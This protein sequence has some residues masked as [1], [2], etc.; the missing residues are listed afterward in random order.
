MSH[1]GLV[2]DAAADGAE[3]GGFAGGA[4][5]LEDPEVD[6]QR[7]PLEVEI[8]DE[9]ERDVV[10]VPEGEH[11]GE[12][13]LEPVGFLLL[14]VGALGAGPDRDLELGG[15]R[16]AVDVGDDPARTGEL[17]LRRRLDERPRR[18]A[19]PDLEH[20]AAVVAPQLVELVV[21]EQVVQRHPQVGPVG[22][23]LAEIIE[24][25]LLAHRQ[26]VGLVDVGAPSVAEQ[27]EIALEPA[28]A[29]VGQH[30]VGAHRQVVVEPA[31]VAGI[32][33]EVERA[34]RHRGAPEQGVVGGPVELPEHLLGGRRRGVA[35]GEQFERVVEIFLVPTGPQAGLLA[36]VAHPVCERPARAPGG[37][38]QADSRRAD[39]PQ[40][41]PALRTEGP[42]AEQ[43][44]EVP[45]VAGAG[46]IERGGLAGA[47]GVVRRRRDD[48][49]P[50][51]VPAVGREVGD[52]IV[53][54]VLAGDVA[55]VAG[56]RIPD[57]EP[58]RVGDFIARGLPRGLRVGEDRGVGADPLVGAELLL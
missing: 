14:V 18:A 29:D 53:V 12:A 56:E 32:G 8:A 34:A 42:R 23:P 54:G 44:D 51:R 27:V 17:G 28:F 22:V 10:G 31:E 20:I 9:S 7:P 11:G 47:G 38:A 49:A 40:V 2:G 57:A 33:Q 39:R 58:L 21:H 46:E 6:G 48:P 24:H 16:L 37:M 35:L 41:V 55:V 30:R 15:H 13:D 3:R 36:F 4:A 1:H 5:G 26:R 50:E 52:Q 25:V 43:F 45:A 19:A